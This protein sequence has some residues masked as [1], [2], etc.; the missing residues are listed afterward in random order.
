MSVRGRSSRSRRQLDERGVTLVMMALM[1]FL[2]LGFSALAVDYGMIKASKA[3]AQRAVDA[4]ALAGA[5]AFLIPDPAIDK[6]PIAEERARDYA[7]KHTVRRNPITD[8]QIEVDVDVPNTTVTVT[9]SGPQMA[10]W[11]AQTI[12]VPTMAVNALA[13]AHVF[14]TSNAACVMPVAIPD[15]WQNND[16]NGPN[17]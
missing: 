2:A 15:L 7:K 4:A 8:P 9:Y 14:E 5:S 1:L 11:F 6:V 10:L 3:E 12:G 13:A 16:I 17:A